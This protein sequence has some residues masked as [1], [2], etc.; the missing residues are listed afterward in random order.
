M[1][2]LHRQLLVALLPLSDLSLL[3]V[4]LYISIFG[5]DA[6]IPISVIAGRS[7][8][9]HTIAALAILLFAWNTSFSLIGLY[10]SKRLEP[11]LA[12]VADVVTAAGLATLILAG[13]SIMFR[14]HVVTPIVLLRFLVLTAC[15]LITARTTMRQGLRFSRVRGR[16]LR[17]VVIVGTN[18]RAT[19]FATNLLIR[20][21]LGY[22]VVGFVDDAWAGPDS[23]SFGP[24]ALVSSIGEFRSYLRTQIIDEVVIAL[25]VKSFYEQANDII[26]TC[27][28][29]G[30][31][32]RVLTSVFDTTTPLNTVHE[33]GSAPVVTFSSVPIDTMRLVIK[34]S[35]DI[36]GSTVLLM[37]T[38]P[39][40]FAAFAL[41]RLDSKGPAIFTQER[42]GL[43]KRRFRIY[44]F[45][46]MV[47]N[48]EKLQWQLES[49]NEA[50]GP[51]FKISND[52]RITRVGRFLRKASIDELPQLVNV[53]KGDMSLV[54][55]RPL[56][57]RDY[58][59]FSKD[60]Q[61]RRF[62][63]RPG[64]TCL[65]QIS[66]R[67]GIPFDQWMLLDMQY[68]DEWSLW[69]DFKILI[70]TLPAVLKGEGAA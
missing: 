13:I 57:L 12:Q 51:V 20:S 17:N 8:Q 34:R 70:K 7:M 32:V 27:R 52:P 10:R 9:V 36:L 43:N 22:R 1:T 66:G 19:D 31:I 59:G 45:R 29:H 24:S 41:I 67:S 21:E 46:T 3:G 2:S 6:F 56:P 69:L 23:Q 62:S 4:I 35:V 26:R 38:S 16:N 42:I 48:A 28:E 68:L 50:E 63:V 53:L 37:L 25:P 58:E 55:P 14:V 15:S 39:F 64:I 5:R 44:K 33:L 47:T 18:I 40:L 11:M 54:G 61:R 65:W 49:R 30:V 60:W